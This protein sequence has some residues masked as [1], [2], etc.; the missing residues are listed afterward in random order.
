MI[1]EKKVELTP[2]FYSGERQ[3][4]PGDLADQGDRGLT[5]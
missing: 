2:E 4:H 5:I 3:K 1:I